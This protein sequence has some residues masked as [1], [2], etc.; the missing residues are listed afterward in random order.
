MCLSIKSLFWEINTFAVYYKVN[1]D[2][3]QEFTQPLADN[4]TDLVIGCLE[5]FKLDWISSLH[6]NAYESMSQKELF[7]IYISFLHQSK[8]K[9]GLHLHNIDMKNHFG[10]LH[11]F[12]KVDWLNL[13][14]QHLFS[15][16]RRVKLPNSQM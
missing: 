15:R 3:F 7:I 12:K 5:F 16:S 13:I 14:L 4:L 1:L 9:L 10:L 2:W 6:I 8:Q 11:S